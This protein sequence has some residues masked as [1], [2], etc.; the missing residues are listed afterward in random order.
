MANTEQQV[1]SPFTPIVEIL[2]SVYLALQL[3][4]FAA[5]YFPGNNFC[6]FILRGVGDKPLSSSEDKAKTTSPVRGAGYEPSASSDVWRANE[7][8]TLVLP[9]SIGSSDNEN[10]HLITVASTSLLG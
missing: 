8:A 1:R 5:R 10:Y 9:T 4:A 6:R 2:G 3:A 7:V